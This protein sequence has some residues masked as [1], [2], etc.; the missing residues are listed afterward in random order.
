MKDDDQ[1]CNDSLQTF[2]IENYAFT[3]TKIYGNLRNFTIKFTDFYY[4]I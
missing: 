1:K 3:F 4:E 2:T